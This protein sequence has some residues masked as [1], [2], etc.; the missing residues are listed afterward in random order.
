MIAGKLE[1]SE[2]TYVI[3]KIGTRAIDLIDEKGEKVNYKTDN[4]T[5]LY[6]A[7][8]NT[9]RN[10]SDFSR[11]D[12]VYLFN[13]GNVIDKLV[14]MDAESNINTNA[15]KVLKTSKGAFDINLSNSWIRLENGLFEVSNSSNIF[16]VEAEGATVTRLETATLKDIVEKAKVGSDLKAY[17]ISERDFNSLNVG[18]QVRV[19]NAADVAHTI[20]FTDFVLDDEL[21]TRET[22]ELS[23]SYDPNNDDEIIGKD[24]KGKDVEFVVAGFA[25]LPKLKAGDIVTVYLDES[26]EVI[27]AEVRING[28]SE[29]YDVVDVESRSSRIK[30]ITVK[31]DGKEET[32]YVSS[33]V[34]IFGDDTFRDKDKIAFDVNEDGDIEVIA[35]F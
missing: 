20:I 24:V 19:G 18:N 10:L 21:L 5:K 23:Y 14:K 32:F 11:G 16:V 8:S 1:Y 7:K 9:E 4:F 27:N 22:I 35:T 17:V 31:N 15:K 28:S 34:M 3:D 26:E 33:D 25:K 12:I 30:S 29:V 2:G 6:I 13:D